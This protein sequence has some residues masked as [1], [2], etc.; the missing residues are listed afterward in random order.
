MYD[1]ELIICEEQAEE[2]I[3]CDIFGNLYN[4]NKDREDIPILK[5][6]VSI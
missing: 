3:G 2:R 6:K 5:E 4:E 1:P